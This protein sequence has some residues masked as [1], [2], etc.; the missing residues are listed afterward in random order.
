MELSMVKPKTRTEAR[1]AYLN[2]K[3]SG[4]PLP[5]FA[6]KDTVKIEFARRLQAAMVAKGWRQSELARRA[7]G[8]LPGGK[9]FGRDSISLYI[10]GK[11]LPGPVLLEALCKALDKT[12]EDL[13]PTRGMPHAGDAN[14]PLDVKDLSDGNVWLRINQAV[15]W[16]KAL[17]IMRIL[18]GDEDGAT[19]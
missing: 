4:E 10:R 12:P 8:Y 15:P 5:Q 11:T 16:G 14:P 3:P 1:R 6:P 13:L 18:K 9:K 17:E 19:T 7:E 2:P